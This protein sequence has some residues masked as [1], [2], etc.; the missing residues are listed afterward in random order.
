MTQASK[1]EVVKRLKAAFQKD[2]AANPEAAAALALL[3][4]VLKP[5]K[6]EFNKL[7]ESGDYNGAAKVAAKAMADYQKK[8]QPREFKPLTNNDIKKLLRIIAKKH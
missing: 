1:E 8:N 6:K 5:V 4:K 2:L 3:P 7:F